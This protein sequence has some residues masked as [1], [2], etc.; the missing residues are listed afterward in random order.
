MNNNEQPESLFEKMAELT[1]PLDTGVLVE[2]V[3]QGAEK[4]IMGEGGETQR[5]YGHHFRSFRSGSEWQKE[6]DKKLVNSL[7]NLMKHRGKISTAW[8]DSDTE[9]IIKKAYYFLGLDYSS[10]PKF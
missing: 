10:E 2:T 7:I 1:K 6:Q 8:L 5:M 3:E 4:W 9:D